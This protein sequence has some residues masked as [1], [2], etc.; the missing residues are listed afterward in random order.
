MGLPRSRLSETLVACVEHDSDRWYDD[1]KVRDPEPIEQVWERTG[2][3]GHDDERERESERAAVPDD[4]WKRPE[5]LFAVPVHVFDVLDDL[6][7]ERRDGRALGLALALI[8]VAAVASPLPYL[9]DMF[10]AA[11][12][13]I[14]A[15]AV[16]V[17]LYAGYEGFADPTMGRAHLKY[18]MFLAI[19]SF[20]VGRATLVVGI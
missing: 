12:L 13:M 8:L 6:P 14:V 20:V 2:E 16:G 1:H 17:M 10:G 11:Y 7:R 18:G 3:D 4:D 15:Q 5:P 19:L 9:L